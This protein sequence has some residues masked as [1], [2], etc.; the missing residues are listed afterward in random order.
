MIQL[1]F[2]GKERKSQDGS[3]ALNTPTTQNAEMPVEPIHPHLKPSSDPICL[4]LAQIQ[5]N[6]GSCQSLS[7]YF[8]LQAN[9]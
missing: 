2:E 3:A 7:G 1:M 5:K 9:S 6:M 4:G 8:C